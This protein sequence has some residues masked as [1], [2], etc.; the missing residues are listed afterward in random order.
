MCDKDLPSEY[1]YVIY[2]VSDLYNGG[3]TV[4]MGD[5]TIHNA[6]GVEIN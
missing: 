6:K 3:M 1:E 4:C 2:Y 5:I